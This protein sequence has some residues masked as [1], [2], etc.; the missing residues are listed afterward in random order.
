MK[1]FHCAECD[2]KFRHHSGLQRHQRIHQG[3][4]PYHCDACGKDFRL[5]STLNQHKKTHHTPKS[6]LKNGKVPCRYCDKRFS[7]LVCLNRHI[8]IKHPRET[9]PSVAANVSISSESPSSLADSS[10]QIAVLNSPKEDKTLPKNV[11]EESSELPLEMDVSDLESEDDN[12]ELQMAIV[13][14]EFEE[15]VH[16][17]ELPEGERESPTSSDK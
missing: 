17:T 3:I 13:N 10:M 16:S 5:G 15:E 4:K 14:P 12:S 9:P 6:E 7:S 8:G 11:A 2:K 1:A